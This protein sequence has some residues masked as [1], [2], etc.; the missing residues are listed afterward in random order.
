MAEKRKNG[1]QKRG[2]GRPTKMTPEVVGKLEAGFLRGLNDA[3]CCLY[4]GISRDTLYDYCTKNP[5]F[6]DRKEL[7]KKQPAVQ[8]KINV[9]EAIDN[10]DV[11]V[12][13]WYL[14]RRNRSEFAVRQQVEADMN[15]AV[16]ISVELV[17]DEG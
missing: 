6:S 8:A 15:A 5:D 14:E 7:L 3:E 9:T 17:D 4:A 11:D 10:G 13:K 16:E 1:E 2:R 12:S